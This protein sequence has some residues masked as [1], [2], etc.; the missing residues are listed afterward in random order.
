[1]FLPCSGRNSVS[2]LKLW[3]EGSLGF[4]QKGEPWG[5]VSSESQD[6]H[7]Q[8]N[9]WTVTCC[10]MI[11]WGFTKRSHLISRET[12]LRPT[13]RATGTIPGT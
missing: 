6:L 13:G 8:N 5:Q 3:D 12:Q 1:M 11:R 9:S 10:W 2:V 4:V 7:D